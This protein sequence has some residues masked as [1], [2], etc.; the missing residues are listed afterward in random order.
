MIT[1]FWIKGWMAWA[2]KIAILALLSAAALRAQTIPPGAPGPTKADYLAVT[3]HLGLTLDN[4]MQTLGNLVAWSTRD[5]IRFGEV[6]WIC[7]LSLCS[8]CS[9]QLRP[10]PGIALPGPK[11]ATPPPFGLAPMRM[12]TTRVNVYDVQIA[13]IMPNGIF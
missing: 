7:P 8:V 4:H 9:P 6:S 12:R 1:N 10:L 3:Q 5:S 2:V 11:P 13:F